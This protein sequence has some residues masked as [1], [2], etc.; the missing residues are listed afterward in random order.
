MA[1]RNRAPREI[2][3]DVSRPHGLEK[4][5]HRQLLQQGGDQYSC[6]VVRRMP[7]GVCLEG[8]VRSAPDL[9]T[10]EQTALQVPGVR[11]VLNH[12]VQCTSSEAE[13]VADVG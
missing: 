9:V 10:A 7:N 3:K 8:V 4:Q 12:L 5:V 13:L 2:T 6:I 11:N 1:R